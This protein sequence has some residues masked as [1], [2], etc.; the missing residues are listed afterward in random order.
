V[1]NRPFGRRT[2]RHDG[3]IDGFHADYWR[4]LD[5]DVVVVVLGNTFE[6]DTAFI[7]RTVLGLA[8]GEPMPPLQGR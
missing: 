1:I 6:N 8:I 2:V 4:D 5:D 3:G 7:A